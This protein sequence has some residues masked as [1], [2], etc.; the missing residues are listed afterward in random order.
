M[1]SCSL[2]VGN[3]AIVS[4]TMV[5][6]LTD[7]LLY[8]SLMGEWVLVFFSHVVAVCPLNTD[9]VYLVIQTENSNIFVI[10]VLI[11][12]LISLFLLSSLACFLMLLLFPT[13]VYYT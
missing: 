2:S 10:P 7:N 8:K 1:Y 9:T 5:I 4:Q 11:L 12:S 13:G 3:T 6:C